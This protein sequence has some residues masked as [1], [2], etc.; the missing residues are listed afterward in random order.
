[1]KTVVKKVVRKLHSAIWV[2]WQTIVEYVA[3]APGARFCLPWLKLALVKTRFC[4]GARFGLLTIVLDKSGE[5][6]ANLDA[7]SPPEIDAFHE[8]VVARNYPLEKVPFKPSLVADCGANIG[9]FSG[10]ARVA[11]PDAEIFAWEPDAHNFRRLNEQPVLQAKCIKFHAAVSDHEGRV[12]VSGVGTGCKVE[13]A[14][15]EDKGVNCIDFGKWWE[16]HAVPRSLLKIDIEGH[17]TRLLPTL[18]GRW[19]A[20]CVVFLETHA[21]A[22]RDEDTIGNL[23]EAGFQVEMLRSH[24]LPKDERIFKEYVALLL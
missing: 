14:T 23:R 2:R 24:S 4:S 7:A 6:L 11:F 10:L 13:E 3:A 16:E 5:R 8:V 18:K 19:K 21:A 17:E 1:M 12:Q 9:L 15:Q 20:P 22:G